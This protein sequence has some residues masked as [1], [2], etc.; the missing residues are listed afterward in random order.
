M[1]DIGRL[2][3]ETVPIPFHA[4]MALGALLIG[5]FQLI[6]PK[7]TGRHRIFGWI[8]V[9]LMLGVAI[10]AAFIHEIRL[11]GAF[12]PIH[13]LIPVVIY[14]LFTGIRAARRGDVKS[15]RSTMVSMFWLALVVTGAFTLLPGRAMH[16]V[17]FG[18]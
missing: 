9:L 1:F 12:S 5:I 6:L 16:T 7:G 18:G 14:G 15:H 17:V 3:A 11:W 2:W 8:W 13:I 10:T 4:L